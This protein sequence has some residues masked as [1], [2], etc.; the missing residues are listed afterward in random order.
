ML[1][2]NST[3]LLGRLTL[4]DHRTA[5]D[6]CN[7]TQL[8]ECPCRFYFAWCSDW[9]ERRCPHLLQLEVARLSLVY[10]L[11]ETRLD[12]RFLTWPKARGFNTRVTH[13]VIFLGSSKPNSFAGVHVR[14]PAQPVTRASHF[15]FMPGQTWNGPC[16]SEL[17][18]RYY[19][20]LRCRYSSLKGQGSCPKEAQRLPQHTDWHIPNHTEVGKLDRVS[21]H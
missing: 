2:L 7:A 20:I 18:N 14:I 16:R 9:T 21:Q 13:Q 5:L 1:R 11:V 17:L 6:L 8:F 3:V 10:V 4:R 19:R 15:Y 12:E